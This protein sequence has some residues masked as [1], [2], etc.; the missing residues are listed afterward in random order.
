[1]VGRERERGRVVDASTQCAL[2]CWGVV[3]LPPLAVWKK[4]RL[5]EGGAWGGKGMREGR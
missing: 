4:K 5:V 3:T 1:M 2:A